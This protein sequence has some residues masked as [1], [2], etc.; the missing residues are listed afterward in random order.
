MRQQLTSD[1]RRLALRFFAG[2]CACLSL[3]LVLA[4]QMPRAPAAGPAW[5]WGN[6]L[7]YLGLAACLLLFIYAGRPR[8][9]PPFHG[10]FF[11]S[12][13]RDLGYAALWLVTGHVGLLLYAEP[14]L[15]E[16][17]KPTAPLYM[18]AGLAALLLL[19]VLVISSVTGWR[20]R[21]WPDYRRFRRLH[22]WLAIACVALTGW[23]V[24]GSHFYLNSPLKLGTGA[25]AVVVVIG[26]Y[27]RGRGSRHPRGR[28]ELARRTPPAYS[29]LLA[30]GSMLLL[31]L[32]ALALVLPE[33]PQ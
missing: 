6:A 13:H 24:A 3:P 29:R 15:L 10:R 33:L 4:S 18:L 31:A 2:L 19:L 22:G 25:L 27:L 28:R 8:V 30:Y 14:L 9:F 16:Y 5:D 20:K 23:H 17:L 21:L 1:S 32:A 12:L 7:G 11:A 26:C